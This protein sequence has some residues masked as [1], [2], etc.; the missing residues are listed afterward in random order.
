LAQRG[1]RLVAVL[2]HRLELNILKL[3]AERLLETPLVP[4]GIAL[5]AKKIRSLI[6]VNT[7][8]LPAATSEVRIHL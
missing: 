4:A 5:R 7:L 2:Y 8:H 6:V 3:I 1:T